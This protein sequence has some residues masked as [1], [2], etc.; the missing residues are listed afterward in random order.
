MRELTSRLDRR[1]LSLFRPE[2][3][4]LQAIVVEGLAQQAVGL[5]LG[6]EDRVNPPP[7]D[8]PR[9]RAGGGD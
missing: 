7:V 2:R 6:H 3:R 1:G 9:I 8:P 4:V 5:G